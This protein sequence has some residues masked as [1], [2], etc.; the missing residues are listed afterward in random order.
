MR[1]AVLPRRLHTHGLIHSAAQ[2]YASI[3]SLH[4]GKQWMTELI[5]KLWMVAW[6]QWEHCNAVL[7][8]QE[9]LIQREEVNKLNHHI[10]QGYQEYQPILPSTDQHFFLPPCHHY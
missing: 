2:I 9:N 7:H 4:M 1:M 5:K 6:D 8:D 3:Q 10:T